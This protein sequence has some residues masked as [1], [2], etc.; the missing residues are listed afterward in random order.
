MCKKDAYTSILKVK[1]LLVSSNSISIQLN[2]N[3]RIG[4]NRIKLKTLKLN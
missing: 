1:P 3:E 2:Q 4:K